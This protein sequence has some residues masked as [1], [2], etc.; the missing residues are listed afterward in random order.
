MSRRGKAA[1]AR[2]LGVALA[3]PAPLRAAL[4]DVDSPPLSAGGSLLLLL[5]L[6]MVLA[7]LLLLV[8]VLALWLLLLLLLT[9]T[10][11]AAQADPDRPR[12]RCYSLVACSTFAVGRHLTAPTVAPPPR[13]TCTFPGH[14]HNARK[15]A[16]HVPTLFLSQ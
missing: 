15:R 14:A 12:F 7:R 10:R 3:L 9:T 11:P 1:E 2:A 5:L 16:Q 8:C 13:R 6:P 4:V